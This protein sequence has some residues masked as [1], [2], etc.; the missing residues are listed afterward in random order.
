MTE[1]N[2]NR[3][4][5]SHE[6]NQVQYLSAPILFEVAIKEYEIEA[7]RKRDIE[8]RIGVLMAIVG[9]LIGFYAS[10]VKFDKIDL[11]GNF[12][13]NIGALF[14]IILFLLPLILFIVTFKKMMNLLSV[15]EYQRIGLGG[16]N[17]E[18]AKKNID[19]T[20]IKLAASYKTVIDNNSKINHEKALKYNESIKW[21]YA[22][23]ISVGIV[24]IV[25]QM[26]EKFI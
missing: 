2:D 7:T 18:I 1:S 4:E 17:K 20:A 15:T 22:S 10:A 12:M 3:T 25:N 14:L 8:T 13:E 19:D 26:I 23:I 9:V 6:S 24:F 16:I 21:L 11:K 5:S